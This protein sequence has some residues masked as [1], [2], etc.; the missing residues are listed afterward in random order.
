MA[1]GR[2]GR[3][4]IHLCHVDDDRDALVVGIKNP[5]PAVVDAYREYLRDLTGNLRVIFVR[6]GPAVRHAKK[7]EFNRPLVGGLGITCPD[8]DGEG[9]I[10]VVASRHGERGFVTA[11]HV[12]QNKDVTCYQP[13]KSDKNDWSA[14]RATV[15]SNYKEKAQSDSAFA[16]GSTTLASDQIWKSANSVYTVTGAANA[17]ALGTEVFM[18]GSAMAGERSGQLAA[19]GVTVDFEDGGVLENQWLAN[20]DSRT[21]DSGAP[22][23]LKTSGSTVE[24][25]GLNVGATEVRFVHPVPDETKYPP[26]KGDLYGIISPWS[27]VVSDLGVSL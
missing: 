14:G 19:T 7:K 17:P 8:V 11:G 6:C 1:R 3:F 16:V 2:S 25:L 23:Y 18:Q 22:V 10:C 21:G 13:R 5:E 9:T 27:N 4:P 15:V 24:L 20:Y 12:V 26:V